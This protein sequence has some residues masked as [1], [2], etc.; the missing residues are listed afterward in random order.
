MKLARYPLLALALLAGL[1]L[2][3]A[4]SRED[5]W[6]FT[7]YL[8]DDPVGFHRFSLAEE[9]TGRNIHSEARFDV[10]FFII[11]AYSY[12]HEAEETWQGDCLAELRA[13][14]DDNGDQSS[15]SGS[16]RD[17]HFR[18]R[19]GPEE[20]DL[21]AC[22]MSFAYWHPLMI[23]QK[24]LLNPQTGEYNE[25][26]IDAKGQESIPVRGQPVTA[27]R[28]RLDAGKFR[29][30]LWYADGQRWVALDSLLENGRK[31]RYR[32]E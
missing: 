21:P 3:G 23:K 15:V 9:G 14:T 26:R 11:N 18:L 5:I 13:H 31:L 12:A 6:N 25:V 17:G 28:Y 20:T 10:K 16:E 32:I 27:Q 19:R 22:V 30:D 7:V 24:R 8:D 4:A 2:P 1:P 29:I